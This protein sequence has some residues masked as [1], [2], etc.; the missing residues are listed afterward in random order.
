MTESASP[1][2]ESGLEG[3]FVVCDDRS[4]MRR[5]EIYDT[6][7]RDGAQGEGV[8]FSLQDKLL[9][10]Q[11]LDS[12]GLRLH[13]RR[14]SGLEREGLPV[15]PARRRADARSTPRSAPSA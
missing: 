10:T 11:R 2:A 5:I 1:E 3:F 8:S 4:S 9:L 7:L 14:L 6:T 13:R 12:L 15:L